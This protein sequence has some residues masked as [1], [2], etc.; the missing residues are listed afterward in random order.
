MSKYNKISINKE[1]YYTIQKIKNR[2]VTVPSD[3]L[4]KKQKYFMNAIK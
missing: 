1:E 3:E 4:K 2:V